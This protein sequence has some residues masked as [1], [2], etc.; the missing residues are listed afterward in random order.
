[1]C[2]LMHA[3][4]NSTPIDGGGPSSILLEADS[5]YARPL[6]TPVEIVG[7]SSD[8]QCLVDVVVDVNSF[9]C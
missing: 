8:P 1:M 7:T 9:S 2:L 3:C 6:S 5:P 4:T